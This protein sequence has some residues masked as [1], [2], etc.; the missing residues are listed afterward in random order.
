M[1]L[2]SEGRMKMFSVFSYFRTCFSCCLKLLF[3]G[4][5]FLNILKTSVFIFSALESGRDV[6]TASVLAIYVISL[7]AIGLG[8]IVKLPSLVKIVV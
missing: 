3:G 6:M 8:V 2:L 5:V 7:T 4:L 1:L